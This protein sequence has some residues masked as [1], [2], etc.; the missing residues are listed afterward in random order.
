MT[1]P[2]EGVRIAD[3]GTAGVG[4]WAASILGL[5]GA[6]V[7]KIDSPAGDRHLYQTPLQRGLSTTYT[8]LNLNKRYAI[9][10]MKDP[11]TRPAIER[12]IRQAD[13][14]MDNLRPGVV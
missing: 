10:D 4:P 3:V 7:L 11:K 13:V 8:S 9:I 6:E 2:L 5:L 1:G 14:V 12:I